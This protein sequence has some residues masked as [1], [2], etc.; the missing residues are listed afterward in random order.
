MSGGLVFE[1]S[2]LYAS[3][4]SMMGGILH[5]PRGGPTTFPPENVQTPIGMGKYK[6]NAV[7]LYASTKFV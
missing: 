7:T 3:S 5:D 1:I 6:Q 4:S 2:Y